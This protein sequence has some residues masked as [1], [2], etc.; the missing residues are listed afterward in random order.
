M[1]G[2]ATAS[3]AEGLGVNLGNTNGINC[4]GGGGGGGGAGTGL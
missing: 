1:V 3:T 4:A 2:I